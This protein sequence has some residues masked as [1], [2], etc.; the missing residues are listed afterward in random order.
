M[1]LGALSA[2]LIAACG[3][4]AHSNLL[5]G[6]DAGDFADVFSPSGDGGG[7]G[8]TTADGGCGAGTL[9]CGHACVFSQTDDDNCGKC[10]NICGAGL[11][12]MSGVCGCPGGLSFC[13]STCLGTQRDPNNC[14]A[15]NHKCPAGIPCG[16]GACGCASGE[17]YC[18]S[19]GTCVDTLTDPTNCGKC[20]N[21]CGAR[22]TCVDGSCSCAAGETDCGAGVGCVDLT[23]DPDHCGTTCPGVSCPS[24]MCAGGTCANTCTPGFSGCP[25]PYTCLD[26]GMC[27]CDPSTP[28]Y[29]AASNTCVDTSSDPQNCGSC[30]HACDAS[31]S[32][33]GG[34]CTAVACTLE[35][36]DACTPDQ[37]SPCCDAVTTPGSVCASVEVTFGTYDTNST[38]QNLCCITSGQACDDAANG[39]CCGYMACDGTT[40]VCQEAGHHCAD[41]GD[42]CSGDCTSAHICDQ[43]CVLSG[44]S[45]QEGDFCC[46][47]GSTNPGAAC[48]MTNA[49]P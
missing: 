32:C 20:D 5:S 15:C 47:T 25:E 39:T 49:C 18:S 14:G 41:A 31:S 44:V 40:C 2:A 33:V 45:C 27:G 28:D 16:G 30:G 19:S 24:G 9:L 37:T 10:G 26:S 6:A 46:A 8:K 13:D 7:D 21:A 12:C 29:C 11:A 38:F 42:C 34:S 17:T 3:D 43:K 23:S 35:N 48:P 36:N 1:I 4:S 22:K